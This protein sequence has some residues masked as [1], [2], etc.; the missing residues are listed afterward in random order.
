MA[1]VDPKRAALVQALME[2]DLYEM[3][4]VA[5]DAGD[6]DIQ[7]AIARRT[8]WV[9]ETPM[10]HRDREAEMHWLAW[11]ERA[12]VNDPEI[13]A[14]YDA[15]LDRKAAAEARAVESRKRVR[16]LHEARDMLARRE[17]GR[18]VAAEPTKA[19]RSATPRTS[20]ASD[21]PAGAGPEVIDAEVEVA[22]VIEVTETPDGTIVTDVTEV[23]TAVETDDA[24]QVTD[25]VDVVEAVI[26]DDG[27][28]VVEVTDTVT[29]TQ[30]AD[31][32]VEVDEVVEVSEALVTEDGV[33]IVEATDAVAITETADGQVEVDEVVEVSEAEIVREDEQP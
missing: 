26:T 8:E 1:T 22:E 31:G 13:R 32:A 11:A 24:M 17:A 12:L 4:D 19:A 16:K 6:A 15:A 20:S 18:A 23:V 3:L 25:T 30:T 27:V 29:I 14:E 2:R 28:D 7:A 21:A 9:E 10:K 33:A 5:R